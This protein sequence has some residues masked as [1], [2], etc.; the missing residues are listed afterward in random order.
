MLRQ[1]LITI[2]GGNDAR[3]AM[4]HVNLEIS[5]VEIQKGNAAIISVSLVVSGITREEKLV[6]L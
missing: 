6:L 2:E 4:T 1:R 5:P 3:F